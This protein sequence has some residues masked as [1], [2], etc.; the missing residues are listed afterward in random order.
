MASVPS[1]LPSPALPDTG[2]SGLPKELVITSNV[3]S[4]NQLYTAYVC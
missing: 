3:V 2:T 4:D 1:P